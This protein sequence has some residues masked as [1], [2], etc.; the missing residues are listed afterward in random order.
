[1]MEEKYKHQ[2]NQFITA[3]YVSTFGKIQDDQQQII[4]NQGHLTPT[5]SKSIFVQFFPL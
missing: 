4:V 1:M 2:S 5:D 3:L